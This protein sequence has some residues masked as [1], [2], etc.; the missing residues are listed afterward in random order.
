MMQ[1]LKKKMQ[2]NRELLVGMLNDQVRAIELDYS[3]L[4]L[5]LD[6]P[7]RRED[8]LTQMLVNPNELKDRLAAFRTLSSWVLDFLEPKYDK[9]KLIVPRSN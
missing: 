8:I 2:S 1:P 4:R 9:P 6:N 5:A 7:D 3:L